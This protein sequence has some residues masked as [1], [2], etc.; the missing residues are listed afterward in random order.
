MCPP[1][2]EEILEIM[3]PYPCIWQKKKL[4]P[5]VEFLPRI[6]QWQSLD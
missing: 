2:M 3:Q 5:R 1:D 6:I 4:C